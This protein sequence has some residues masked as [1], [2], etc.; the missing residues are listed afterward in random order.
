LNPQ[1]ASILTSKWLEVR[2]QYQ[3][4]SENLA[5]EN[6]YDIQSPIGL[7]RHPR[8]GKVHSATING[9]TARSVARVI[10]RRT[11]STVFE[12]DLHSGRPH[13]IRIHLAFIGHPLVGD[14]LYA[15][16]GTPKADNPG[17]PGDGGYWLHAK[18]LVFTHP[19]NG[20]KVDV[21]ADLPPILR[22]DFVETM[23]SL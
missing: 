18:R 3:A 22:S 21:Q 7:S 19:R 16:G 2:K 11:Q 4:L 8:L 6:E 12:V 1:T 23:D 15:S 17:L 10:Q 14:P 9:K 20:A 13:Q 5:I